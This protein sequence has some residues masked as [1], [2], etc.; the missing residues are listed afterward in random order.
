MQWI[1]FILLIGIM[2]PLFAGELNNKNSTSSFWEIYTA[3]LRG[4][5]VA[6]YKTGVIYEQGI[7]VEQ[8]QT[9]AVLWY[10]KSA[11]QGYRDAQYNLALMNASGRGVDKNIDRAMVW[12]AKAAKQGDKEARVLLLQII[13]GKFDEAKSPFPSNGEI[14]SITPVTLITKEG[15]S[16]CSLQNECSVYKTNTFLTSKSKRG[17]YYQI[18]GIGTS[19]GWKPFEKDGWIEEDNVEIKK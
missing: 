3:A 8:N 4:D 15:A 19:N 14:E 9:Q 2:N 13:D 6:Q 18:S 12:L 11:W 1:A 7:G 5:K 17:K 10:E 16:V